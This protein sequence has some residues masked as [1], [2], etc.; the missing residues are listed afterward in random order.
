M[1]K[2]IFYKGIIATL[3]Q[4]VDEFARAAEELSVPFLVLSVKEPGDVQFAKLSAFAAEGRC[5]A[6]LFNNIGLNLQSAEGN[7]WEKRRIPVFNLLVDH[8]RNFDQ[9]L[10]H[11]MPNLHVLTCDFL[12][13]AFC[14]IFFPN[15]TEARFFPH[16]GVLP[17]YEVLPEWHERTIDILYIGNCNIEVS[18]PEIPFFSDGGRAWYE[19]SIRLLLQEP[20]RTTEDVILSVM[21]EMELSVTE[22]ELHLLMMDYAGYVETTVRRRH[23]LHIM[24]R[25]AEC[26]LHVEIYGSHWED[27]TRDATGT[28]RVHRSISPEECIRLLGKT[29]I[30]LNIQP[31]F[32]DGSHPRVFDAM[33]SG[34]IC[35]T[36]KS[37][38]LE[39]RF[40]DGEELVFY[41]LSDLDALPGKLQHLL[42]QESE[43]KQIA[44]RGRKAAQAQDTWKNRL[45]DLLRM[46]DASYQ[47]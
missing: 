2:L 36:D 16:G 8:P 27:E 34:A 47:S 32:K 38:Y 21:Q 10:E 30:A 12:H 31:W 15:L 28:V 29:K 6:V 45:E 7:F 17:K 19:R 23:K 13:V 39:D 41:D 25:L 9:V 11:P 40:R 20:F 26:G 14:N 5:A 42:Q 24:R 37:R 46:C 3:D 4:F 35:V 43:A 44:Q 22:E 18:Y 33:L 1:Y